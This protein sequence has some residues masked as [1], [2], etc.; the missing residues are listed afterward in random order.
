MSE[1]EVAYPIGHGL[2]Y[3]DPVK[4]IK[5]NIPSSAQLDQ[6]FTATVTLSGLNGLEKNDYR[7]ALK[8]DTQHFSILPSQDYTISGDT[9]LI[10]KKAND[11]NPVEISLK[12]LVEGQFSP[13]LSLTLIDSQD[14]EFSMGEGYYKELVQIAA[15]GQ[16]TIPGQQTPPQLSLSSVEPV[17]SRRQ[18]RLH[19]LISFLKRETATVCS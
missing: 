13:V 17:S 14:R 11:T 3:T 15:A 7:L 16:N 9:V 19:S 5:V 12:G 10:S 4:D 6:P 1:T 18:L 2:F 8:M